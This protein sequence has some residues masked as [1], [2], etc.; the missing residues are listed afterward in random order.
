MDLFIHISISLCA[1]LSFLK[2]KVNIVTWNCSLINLVKRII[3]TC[4][5]YLSSSKVNRFIYFILGIMIFNY[6]SCAYRVS[7]LPEIL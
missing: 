1:L 3:Y 2:R 6:P 4:Y 5:A 7:L